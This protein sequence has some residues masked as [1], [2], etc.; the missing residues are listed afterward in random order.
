M[1][2]FQNFSLKSHKKFLHS[3]RKIVNFFQC[4]II[5]TP[6]TPQNFYQILTFRISTVNNLQSTLY[7]ARYT[8]IIEKVN[9]ATYI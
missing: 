3:A 8:S 2:I 4:I 9:E 6:K 1:K 7:T 5:Y